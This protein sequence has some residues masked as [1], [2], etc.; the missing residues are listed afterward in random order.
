M[1]SVALM[2]FPLPGAGLP[3]PLRVTYSLLASESRFLS[4]KYVSRFRDKLVTMPP[5]L[6]TLCREYFPYG[7]KG[8]RSG[9]ARRWRDISARERNL[10]RKPDDLRS[11][12]TSGRDAR[13][14]RRVVR[15]LR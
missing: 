12:M 1:A 11:R 14:N 15:P 6:A 3:A 4:R 7:F 9:A 2:W 5:C 10:V 13:R 8:A